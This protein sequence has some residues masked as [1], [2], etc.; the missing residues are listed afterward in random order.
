MK[1]NELW[2]ALFGLLAF[3]IFIETLHMTEHQH[4][5]ECPVIDCEDY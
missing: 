1:I 5:R 3:F 2:L 4:C